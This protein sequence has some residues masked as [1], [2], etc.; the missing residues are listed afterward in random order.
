MNEIQTANS[1]PGAIIDNGID[2]VDNINGMM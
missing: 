2:I 1:A